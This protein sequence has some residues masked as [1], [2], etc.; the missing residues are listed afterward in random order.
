MSQAITIITQPSTFIP[1]MAVQQRSHGIGYTMPAAPLAAGKADQASHY[2]AVRARLL[3]A[4]PVLRKYAMRAKSYAQAPLPVLP[5]AEESERY[6]PHVGW[7]VIVARVATWH[8]LTSKDILG[9]DRTR[10]VVAARH[11]AFFHV[12]VETGL[13]LP[14]IGKRFNRDHTTIMHGVRKQRA[15]IKSGAAPKRDMI[16]TGVREGAT[17]KERCHEVVKLVALKFGV[18]PAQVYG[19]QRREDLARAR[20]EIFLMLYRDHSLN[21]SEIGQGV[22]DRDHATIIKEIGHLVGPK[23]EASA[24]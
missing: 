1:L 4:R 23:D 8:G 7:R 11:E 22:G 6:D 10:P 24:A 5:T 19:N 13:T 17:V 9:D 15:R 2:A 20:Q 16:L 14:Q 18:S 3:G 21:Y 12:V